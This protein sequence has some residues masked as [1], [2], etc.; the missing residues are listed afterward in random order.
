LALLLVIGAVMVM[1]GEWT[2]FE[3]KQLLGRVLIAGILANLAL[4]ALG[5]IIQMSNSLVNVT[6]TTSP[7]SLNTGYSAGTQ[8]IA[9]VVIN[10]FM[11]VI[12][13]FLL[14]M[15][16]FDWSVLG[17]AG[18]FGCLASVTIANPK[19]EEMG[20]RWWKLVFLLALSPILQAL[21]VKIT[22]EVFLNASDM[23]RNIFFDLSMRAGCL[24]VLAAIPVICLKRAVFHGG[25]SALYMRA[26]FMIRKAMMTP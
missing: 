5:R 24:L 3:G 19:T 6:L 9:L 18:M 1:W 2:Y 21:V 23:G 12:T 7:S 25:G 22:V 14:I 20:R 17:V 11:V 15:N 8:S 4:P 16:L 10:V 26:A 13:I